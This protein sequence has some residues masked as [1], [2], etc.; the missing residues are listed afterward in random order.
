MT[1]AAWR[2]NSEYPATMS[3]GLCQM[4]E[5]NSFTLD[6]QI[7]RMAFLKFMEPY[8]CLESSSVA[9]QE[10][11]RR[12]FAYSPAAVIKGGL[13]YYSMASNA[14]NPGQWPISNSACIVI[15]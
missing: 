4:A 9:R 12:S 6:S 10:S 7:L 1:E 14:A 5:Q 2:A 8:E 3:N 11:E 15:L 13:R